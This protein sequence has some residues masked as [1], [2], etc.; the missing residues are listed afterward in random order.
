[1]GWR[2]SGQVCTVGPGA[3]VGRS[4]ATS[5]RAACPKR[6]H[7]ISLRGARALR[8]ARSRTGRLGLIHTA[9]ASTDGRTVLLVGERGV[10]AWRVEELLPAALTAL[11]GVRVEGNHFIGWKGTQR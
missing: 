8:P 4:F 7:L 1:M 9:L 3:I 2:S 5:K 11:D 6:T 10:G